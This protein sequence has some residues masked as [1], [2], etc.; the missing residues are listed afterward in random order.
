MFSYP[1]VSHKLQ[2]LQVKRQTVWT[3]N[4]WRSTNRFLWS[5]NMFLWSIFGHFKKLYQWSIC[6]YWK[7]ISRLP[8][9][10]HL[11]IRDVRYE[12]FLVLVYRKNYTGISIFYLVQICV[13]LVFQNYKKIW[14]NTLKIDKNSG[15]MFVLYKYQKYNNTQKKEGMWL[16]YTGKFSVSR[17]FWYIGIS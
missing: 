17:K 3:E 10:S 6:L 7:R 15:W 14:N 12:N 9:T 16:R 13:K 5:N 11:E 1:I 2:T 8:Q 4:H